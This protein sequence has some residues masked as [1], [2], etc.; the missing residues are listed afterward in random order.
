MLASC[1]AAVQTGFRHLALRHIINPPHEWF[2]AAL[3]RQIAIHILAVRF[4]VPKR[5]IV[6]MQARQRTSINFAVIAIDTR[7]DDPMFERAYRRMSDRAVE[8]FDAKINK[9]AA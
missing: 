6:A 4:D 7:L 2:D 3:A 5:R 1:Y 9:A 8:I